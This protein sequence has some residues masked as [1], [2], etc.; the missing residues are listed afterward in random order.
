LAGR[1]YVVPDDIKSLFVPALRHRVLLTTSAEVEGL[2]ADQVLGELA[3]GVPVP[4]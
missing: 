2:G 3:N 1:E 4:R